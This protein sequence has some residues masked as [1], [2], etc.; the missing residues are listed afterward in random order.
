MDYEEQGH[1]FEY[2]GFSIE[3]YISTVR[4]EAEQSSETD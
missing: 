4:D 3:A 1:G 2:T